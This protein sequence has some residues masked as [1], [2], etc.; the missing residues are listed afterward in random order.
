MKTFTN[1]KKEFATLTGNASTTANTTN[2][3]D[4]I[5][6]GMRM[7]NDA[8]RYL[9]TV[10]Y[11]NEATFT[12]NTVTSQQAYLLPSDF[13]KLMNVTVQVGGLLWQPKESPS[14]KH[15]DSLNVVPFYNDYSQYYFIFQN[16]LLLYPTPAS[17]GNS[18]IFHYKKRITDIAMDDVTDVTS[19]ATVTAS[20]RST[21][22]T[23]SG[24]AFK[25]W[26]G[27][28]GWIQITYNTTDTAN[29]DNKWYEIASVTN[30]TTLILKNAYTGSN[31]VGGSFIIGNVPIL[32][33]DY[34]DLPLYRACRLYHST[35]VPD[36]TKTN[37]F[38]VLYDEGYV[39]LEAKYGS[40]TETPVL[41]DT[42]A[43]VFNPNLFPRNL[44]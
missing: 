1:F 42:D 7:I 33:E 4:N 13:E 37:G 28:G 6:W 26:M 41:T 27:L 11:F 2:T 22:I 30:T 29:G 5:S 10:F 18:L 36:Q 40:K 23:A 44:S 16:Q 17:S 31:V 15:F 32:P 34:Q 8:I 9:A 3:Y 20:N 25:Q 12:Q 39:A 19:S 24:T 14:R 21:T 38:K 43:P 35:R